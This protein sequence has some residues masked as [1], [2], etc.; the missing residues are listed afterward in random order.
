MQQDNR[1]IFISL[2]KYEDSHKRN[3]ISNSTY[4][5]Q[6]GKC[7]GSKNKHTSKRGKDS[8]ATRITHCSILRDKVALRAA[9]M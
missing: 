1:Q 9:A 7:H 2:V 8:C 5:A 3:K 6:V 4:S